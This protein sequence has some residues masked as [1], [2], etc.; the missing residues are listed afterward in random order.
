MVYNYKLDKM[1]GAL[2]SAGAGLLKGAVGGLLGSTG[3]K[4][5]GKLLPIGKSLVSKG[6]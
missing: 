1:W 2:A 5:L 6:V 4:I 3:S